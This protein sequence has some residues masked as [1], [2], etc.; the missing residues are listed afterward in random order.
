MK[1]ETKNLCIMSAV[2]FIAGVAVVPLA[3][4]ALGVAV[5]FLGFFSTN[6]QSQE[7]QAEAFFYRTMNALFEGTYNANE[8]S[9][10]PEFMNAFKKYEPQLGKKCRLY[11]IDSTPGYYECF[12]FFPSGDVFVL[13]IVLMND[14]WILYGFDLRDWDIFWRNAV[15][16]A[17][18]LYR[19]TKGSH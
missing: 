2:S 11:I 5:G 15:E 3:V 9:V 8:G 7:Q 6:R 16:D 19:E 12:T 14:R 1:R 10:S 13:Q 18:R 17:Q 4:V